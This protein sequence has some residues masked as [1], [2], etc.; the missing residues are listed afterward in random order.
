MTCPRCGYC[1]D[2]TPAVVDG[3]L[4][5]AGGRVPLTPTEAILA[6]LLVNRLGSVVPR[7]E[8]AKAADVN[9]CQW[10]NAL[11]VNIARLRQKLDGLPVQVT[12]KQNIGYAMEATE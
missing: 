12:T 10:S 8:L 9:D 4:C 5:V 11:A 3:F 6:G 1:G 7:E 2:S